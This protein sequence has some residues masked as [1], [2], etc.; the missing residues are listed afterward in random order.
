MEDREKLHMVLDD[1]VDIGKE[2]FVPKTKEYEDFLQW[3]MSIKD[4]Y[5][6]K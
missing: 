6:K 5:K 3:A 2:P 4:R 1:T